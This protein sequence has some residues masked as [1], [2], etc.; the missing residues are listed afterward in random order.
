MGRYLSPVEILPSELRARKIPVVV[1]G[2]G[3]FLTIPNVVESA[4][5]TIRRLVR[6]CGGP[7]EPI[8]LASMK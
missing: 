6:Q 4:I 5:M 2:T 8:R 3:N 1:A 7:R